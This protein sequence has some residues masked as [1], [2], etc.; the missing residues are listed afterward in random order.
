MRRL[1]PLLLLAAALAAPAAASADPSISYA[2]TPAPSSCR[3]WYTAP[4]TIDWS[5]T[6]TP[7][8]GTCVDTKVD[9]DT[10]SALQSCS[11]TDGQV[12]DTKGVSLQVDQTPPIVTGA[13]ASRPPDH[14]GWYRNPVQVTFSGADATSGLLGCSSTTYSGPNTAAVNLLGRCQD[15]AGN[16]SAAS[17]FGLAYDSSPPALSDVKVATADRTARLRWKVPD[18]ARVE[19]WRRRGNGKLHHVKTGG[20]KGSVVNRDLSNGRPYTYVVTATDAAGNT[21]SRT[22]TAV[23]GPRL[24]GPAPGV[25]LADPPTL[26]WTAVR[27]AGYYNVQIFRGN[28]K[29]MSVWPERP[30]LKLHRSWSF[31]GH[32]ERLRAGRAYRWFVWP[33]IGA[34][35]RA[36]Y[37]PLVGSRTF[38]FER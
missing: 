33:G 25:H 38:T 19:V 28:R 1:L 7:V 36:D 22:L 16:V 24:L 29:V 2:C 9:F 5:V 11:V 37:G 31:A 32:H 6:G 13:A 15:I 17:P 26:R 20:T 10:K 23:P 34:R 30:R 27:G 18:A 35:A 14:N 4:V 12:T 8:N 3:G 21:A